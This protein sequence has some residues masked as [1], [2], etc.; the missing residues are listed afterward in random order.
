M[1][2]KQKVAC[3]FEKGTGFFKSGKE[4]MKVNKIQSEFST[5]KTCYKILY[6]YKLA[7]NLA[8]HYQKPHKDSHSPYKIIRPVE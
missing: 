7:P 8:L 4:E 2:S 1:P 3:C 5:H 6:C